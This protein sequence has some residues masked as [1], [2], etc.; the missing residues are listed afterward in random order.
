MHSADVLSSAGAHPV[1]L[2][3]KVRESHIVSFDYTSGP[4]PLV[5]VHCADAAS[6]R[7]GHGGSED[8]P[9]SGSAV[10]AESTLERPGPSRQP[11]D[12]LCAT[13]A[14]SLRAAPSKSDKQGPQCEPGH[15]TSE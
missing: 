5:G 10:A 6:N 2:F 11:E 15:R 8:L 3:V 9:A 4:R 14:A 12:D 7:P 13:Q 1:P